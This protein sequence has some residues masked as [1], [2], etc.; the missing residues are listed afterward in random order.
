MK[1]ENP[2]GAG[3]GCGFG[4]GSLSIIAVLFLVGSYFFIDSKINALD[5]IQ[6]G[7]DQLKDKYGEIESFIPLFQQDQV[8]FQQ[9][10]LVTVRI[11]TEMADS[12]FQLFV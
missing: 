11:Q 5:E 3:K 8:F 7:F 12:F 9:D 6:D 4:C 10:Q 2:T 1:N